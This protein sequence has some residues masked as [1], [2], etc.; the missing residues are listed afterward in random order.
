MVV[1]LITEKTPK[2]DKAENDYAIMF[3]VSS[4]GR[5]KI[6]DNLNSEASDF[7]DHCFEKEPEKR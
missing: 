5:P 4:G 3:F 1:E 7:L 2:F 6:P